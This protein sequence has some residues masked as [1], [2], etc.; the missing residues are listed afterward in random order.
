M[1]TNKILSITC[2]KIEF[3]SKKFEKQHI[4]RKKLLTPR[5]ELVNVEGL[6]IKTN[7]F[8]KAVFLYYFSNIN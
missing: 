6:H 3:V 8:T 5:E 1:I 7:K 4:W 2:K